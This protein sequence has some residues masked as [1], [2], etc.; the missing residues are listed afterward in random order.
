MEKIKVLFICHG[1]ICRSTL[2]E[3]VFYLH[4]VKELGLEEQIYTL[5]VLRRV[6]RRLE[7]RLTVWNCKKTS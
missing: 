1:N 7:I 2:A 6:P 4:I 3:S 5:I